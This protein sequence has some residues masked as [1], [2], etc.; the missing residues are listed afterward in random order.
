M[1]AFAGTLALLFAVAAPGIA[2]AAEGTEAA[3]LQ[4][5]KKL[6]EA[7]LKGDVAAMQMMLANDYV[8]I[9]AATGGVATKEDS[10]KSYQ[11]ARLKYDS[12]TPS[13]SKV[14]VY[15]ST[16]ALVTAKVDV[17]GKLGDQDLSGSYRY[18]RLYV[19]RGGKW[20]VVL[21][22]STRIPGPGSS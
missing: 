22:Q 11:T 12:L 8:A 21:L 10:I 6:L 1:H 13:E 18:S 2:S 5:E 7:A 16:T 15:N 4:L 14:H 17:K 3:I 19:K 20:Q 9:S